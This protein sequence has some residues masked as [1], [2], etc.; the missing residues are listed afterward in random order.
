MNTNNK[1]LQLL[2]SI[3][4]ISSIFSCNSKNQLSIYS[5]SGEGVTWKI[6]DFKV[7]KTNSDFLYGSGALINQ[8]DSNASFTSIDYKIN[9]GRGVELSNA[10]FGN[11][12][13]KASQFQWIGFCKREISD[14]DKNFNITTEPKGTVNIEWTE[15]NV[16]YSENFQIT[17][18]KEF[19]E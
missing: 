2:F 8:K 4:L 1:Y 6:I 18:R 16:K 17:G 13:T 9:I 14:I 15:N 11:T 7:I 12:P 5:Y 19:E 3:I 10:F